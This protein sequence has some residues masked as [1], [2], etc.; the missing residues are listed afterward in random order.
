MKRR[1]FLAFGSLFCLNTLPLPGCANST[2]T[3]QP[4]ID[5]YTE[6][7]I[8]TLTALMPEKHGTAERFVAISEAF[9]GTPYQAN[10]LIGSATQPEELVIDFRG[11]DCLILL[12]YVNALNRSTSRD[13]LIQE[14]IRTRYKN[15]TVAFPMRRHFFS[16]WVYDA[17]QLARN[18]TAALGGTNTRTVT[19]NLNSKN[20]TGDV[21]L[22]G[23]PVVK[24]D[25]AYIPPEGLTPAF[26]EGIQSGDLIGIYTPTSGLDAS[27][28]GLAVRNSEGLMF[29]NASSLQKNRKVVDTPLADYMAGKPGLMVFRCV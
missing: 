20:D 23:I 16:D 2:T 7:R 13:M 5:P 3:P 12:E 29:R 1:S 8:R 28:T 25:I 14:V 18:I 21:W 4:E 9:L 15:E 27:H 17:P 26:F 19:K 11:V 22:P 6:E 24:R 10:R